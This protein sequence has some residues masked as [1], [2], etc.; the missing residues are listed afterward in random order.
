MT[1]I[2]NKKKWKNRLMLGVAT[3]GWIRYEWAA[4]RYA[5][6][7][8]LNWKCS[9]FTVSF[10]RQPYLNATAIGFNI[11]D[12]YNTIVRQAIVSDVEW[13][14][15]IEDDVLVPPNL[16]LRLSEYMEEGKTPI[17]SGLYYSKGNPSEPLIFRGRGTG[18]YKDWKRGDK[19]WCDGVPFGCLLIHMSIFRYLWSNSA[20]YTLPNGQK[21]RKVIETPREIF[22]DPQTLAY[23]MK[24]G[25]QDLYWCDRLIKEDVFAKTGWDSYANLKYPFLCDTNIFCEH[26]DRQTGRRYPTC[27]RR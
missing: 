15:F 19:V 17:I 5:Q 6:M 23:H 22:Y 13:L 3:E 20:E 9:D 8:P 26:I 27:L 25:T 18:V 7:I 11:D 14:M 10:S 12:A 2:Y 21:T 4:H 24:M 1:T 16:L